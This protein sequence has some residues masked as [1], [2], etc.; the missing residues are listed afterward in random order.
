MSRKNQYDPRALHRRELLNIGGIGLATLAGAATLAYRSDRSYEDHDG[1]GIPDQLERSSAFH[2]ALED[3]YGPDQFSGLDPN[4]KD[5]LID[6]RYIG[7][8]RISEETK[9][10]LVEL[11]GDHGIFLQWLDYHA[12]YDRRQFEEAYG[13]RV[14]RI[15]W[16]Y[17]S[18][19]HDVVEHRLKNVALQVVVIPED[20]LDQRHLESLYALHQG[21]DYAGI[22]MGNRCVVTD[23]VDKQ[24]DFLLHEIAHL[25]LCHD[26]DPDNT[27]V[28][29]PNPRETD[30]MPHEW[31]ALR[32]RL[33][34]IRDT[35]GFD[36][37]LRDC[38]GEEFLSEQVDRARLPY[39]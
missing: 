32:N 4:R 14:E 15:L 30:L 37:L 35:T 10:K 31:E 39:R 6:V 19:Y 13:Y 2:E 33:P 34:N 8:A 22:S 1:D 11:F 7:F 17:M 25:G 23:S 27:G 26:D 3:I 29:G 20:P 38:V 16:P 21:D 36:I 28:M 12:H 18:F 5:L 24:T 9:E